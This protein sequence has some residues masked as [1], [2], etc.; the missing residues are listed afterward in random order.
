MDPVR[1]QKSIE[2]LKMPENGEESPAPGARFVRRRVAYFDLVY[3]H[4]SYTLYF[5]IA[6]SQF[7]ERAFAI[8]FANFWS[9]VF[10]CPNNFIITN[11]MVAT[12]V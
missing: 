3:Q 11:R 1:E 10:Y 6:F 12:L 8:K 9:D 5:L 7:H 4:L 2:A